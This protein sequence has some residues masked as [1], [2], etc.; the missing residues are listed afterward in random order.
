MPNIQPKNSHSQ[1]HDLSHWPYDKEE[2]YSIEYLFSKL[3]M[4]VGGLKLKMLRSEDGY[5][6]WYSNAR[7]IHAEH[8]DAAE[9]LC[10]LCMLLIRKGKS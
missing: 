9:A 3:P 8:Q 10:R 5:E 4:H 1:L 7:F 6:F 2:S